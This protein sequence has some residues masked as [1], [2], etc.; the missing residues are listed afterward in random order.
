MTPLV[1]TR[2]LQNPLGEP[3]PAGHRGD[4]VRVTDGTA[5]VYLTPLEFDA[6]DEAHLRYLLARRAAER[7]DRAPG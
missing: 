7:G 6:A 5:T 1:V 2:L 4:L 3:A